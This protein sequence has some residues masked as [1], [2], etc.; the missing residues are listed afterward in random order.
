MPL[1][2]AFKSLNSSFWRLITKSCIIELEIENAGVW[3]LNAGAW[4]FK[5]RH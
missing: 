3:H 1:I 4:H 5:R 2:L